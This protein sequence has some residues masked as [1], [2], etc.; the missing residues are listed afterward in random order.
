M[1]SVKA[2]CMACNGTGLYEGFCEEKGHPVICIQ[3]DGSGCEEIR[4]KPFVERKKRKGII[5]VHK[6]LGGFIAT[7]VGATGD[8]ITYE[9]FL[10]NY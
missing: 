3:C 9:E 8:S 6:S 7:G 10:K 5:S 1:V 2:E 4:Y